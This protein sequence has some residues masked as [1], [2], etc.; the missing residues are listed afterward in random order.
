MPGDGRPAVGPLGP[1]GVYVV[2]THSGM[3]LAPILADYVAREVGDGVIEPR[4]APYRPDRDAL[5][6]G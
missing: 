5:T 6:A 1:G 2:S 4:L 3:T